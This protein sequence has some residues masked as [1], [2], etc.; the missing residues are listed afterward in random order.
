MKRAIYVA[1]PRLDIHYGATGQIVPHVHGI[2]WFAPDGGSG[3]E[4][5]SI[6]IPRSDVYVPSEPADMRRHC[7]RPS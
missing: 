5:K 1:A 4:F 7:P 3:T 2:V 6:G